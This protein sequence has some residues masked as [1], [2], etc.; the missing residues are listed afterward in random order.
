MSSVTL[1][2]LT[3]LMQRAAAIAQRLR[4]HARVIDQNRQRRGVARSAEQR[5]AI[6][7][8]LVRPGGFGRGGR[9]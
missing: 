6:E 8:K 9:G 4:R 1:Y 5:P 3:H 2:P 7:S